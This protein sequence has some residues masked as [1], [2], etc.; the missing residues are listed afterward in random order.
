M[1]PNQMCIPVPSPYNVQCMMI[2]KNEYSIPD[3]LLST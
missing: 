2:I 3:F 1:Y